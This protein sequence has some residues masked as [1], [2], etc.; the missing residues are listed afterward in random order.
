LVAL[1]FGAGPVLRRPPLFQRLYRAVIAA[2]SIENSAGS[3]GGIFYI[4][5]QLAVIRRK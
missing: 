4:Y 5:G 2:V 1:Q 3:T